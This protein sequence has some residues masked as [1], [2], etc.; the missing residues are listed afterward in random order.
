[1]LLVK[2]AA[3]VFVLLWST[4]F[5]V[6]RYI[7]GVADPNLFLLLRFLSAALLFLCIALLTKQPWPARKE[8]PKHFL[9]G[10][11]I[12]GFYMGGTYWAIA[13]G[14]PPAVMAL[15]GALQPLL[16]AAIAASIL[17][18]PVSASTLGGI[19]VGI[20]GVSMVLAPALLNH[21]VAHVP[22]FVLLIGV[23]AILS[24]TVGTVLQKTAIGQSNLVTSM[25]IQNLS[26]AMV[27][28]AL[29]LALSESKL[30]LGSALGFA[31][32]WAAIVLSGGGT[33]LLFWLVRKGNATRVTALMLLAPPCAAV[34][35]YWLFNDAL[36]PVQL[37]G[38]AVVLVGTYLC[39]RL[40][41]TKKAPDLA[42]D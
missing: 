28:A 8:L 27:A 40:G 37:A 26:G 3:A 2:F 32:A 42:I 25:A 14:L 29:A 19:V 13:H 24:L 4:G 16:T 5:I 23:L 20:V 6:G 18:E 1:M 9:A 12:N 33:Y 34:E 30:V 35:A 17:R 22:T 7:V 39:Q 38:F 31:L 36:S 10:A 41:A 15:I 11:L 21:G